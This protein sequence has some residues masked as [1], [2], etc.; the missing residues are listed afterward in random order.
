MHSLAPRPLIKQKP[1]MLINVQAPKACLRARHEH[2]TETG[3][4]PNAILPSALDVG[5]RSASSSEHFKPLDN[6]LS[7]TEPI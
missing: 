3:R 2:V 7:R 6:S 5:E 1:G 4:A